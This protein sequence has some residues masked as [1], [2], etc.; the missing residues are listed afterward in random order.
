[1]KHEQTHIGSE[2]IKD[3]KLG[4]IT[5]INVKSK[6]NSVIVLWSEDHSSSEEDVDDLSPH[7]LEDRYSNEIDKFNQAMDL[8]HDVSRNV[9]IHYLSENDLIDIEYFRDL[10]QDIINDKWSSSASC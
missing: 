9:S 6:P 7:S 2:I 5:Y 4:T 3:N 1:M 8:L 10:A